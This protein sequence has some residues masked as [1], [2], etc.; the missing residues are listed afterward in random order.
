MIASLL[1]RGPETTARTLGMVRQAITTQE[2]DH[3]GGEESL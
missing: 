2:R 3:L 1:R